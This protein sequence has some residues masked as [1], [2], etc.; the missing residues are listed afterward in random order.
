MKLFAL[1]KVLLQ[2]TIIHAYPSDYTDVST[3]IIFT[4]LYAVHMKYIYIHVGTLTASFFPLSCLYV[5]CMP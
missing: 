3:I 4:F 5:L 1:N 2:Q